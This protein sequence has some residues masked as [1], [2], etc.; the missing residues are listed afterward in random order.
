MSSTI[1]AAATRRHTTETE[2][3]ERLFYLIAC[4]V[5]LVGVASGFHMFY[6]RGLNDVGQPVTQQSAPLVY[7]HAGL[8]TCWMLLFLLQCT[9]V[10]KGNRGLH[11][12]IGRAAIALYIAIIPVGALAALLQIHYADPQSFPPFGPYRFL[13]LPLTEIANFT[14]FIG[15]AFLFRRTPAMHRA[16]MTIGTLAV[17]E[18]GI[19]RIGFIR[20]AFMQAT[21]AAYF[22]TFWGS[23]IAVAVVLWF[24]KLAVTRRFDR[25]FSIAV[26]LFIAS[27][28][29]SGFVSSTHWWLQ[30]AQYA[31][32]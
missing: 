3:R 18:A 17:A 1:A 23:T 27:G 29:L 26:V 30:F 11:M 14:L 4:V 24:L 16:F 10:V 22:P 25:H 5:M 32:R 8:M 19:G 6:L 31:T 9:L 20:T 28:L 13:A 15:A 21:H 12:Q 7:V 2:R